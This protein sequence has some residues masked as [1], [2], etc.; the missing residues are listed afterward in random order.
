M[1]A[2]EKTIKLYAFSTRKNQHHIDFAIVKLGN[3][4]HDCE[5]IGKS[6]RARY[7]NC[8]RKNLMDVCDEYGIF[9]NPTVVRVPWNI[10]K[11]LTSVTNW[12]IEHGSGIGYL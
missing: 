6:E 2:T 7:Y 11:Y 9:M 10:H 3:M 12:A 1:S 4:Q 8:K 5:T